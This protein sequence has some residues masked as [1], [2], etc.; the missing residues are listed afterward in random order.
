[1]KTKNRLIFGVGK[2]DYNEQIRIDDKQIKSYSIWHAMHQRCYDPK[3]LERF[4]TYVGCSVCPEWISFSNFKIWF[5]ANYIPNFQLDKD[6]LKPGNKEYGPDACRFVPTY[7]NNLLLDRKR[8]RGK[9]PLG[10]NKPK[11]GFLMSCSDGE[12]N[13]IKKYHRTLEEAVAD[14]AVTKARIVKQQADR[15]LAEGSIQ[16]DVYDA[17]ISRN[18]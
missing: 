14:Y 6:I 11:Y 4:P 8:A 1:M 10:V 2:N 9:Y 16:L 17:L 12:G 3:H 7:L 13:I 18:W 5:D 15:A